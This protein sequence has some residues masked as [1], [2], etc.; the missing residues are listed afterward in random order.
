MPGTRLGWAC[1]PRELIAK[2]V[3]S[4]Q[5]TDQCAS[6][7]AQRLLEEYGRR[8]LLD[9]GIER[10]RAIYAARWERTRAALEREMPEGVEWWDTRGGFFTWLTLPRGDTTQLARAAVDAGVVFVPGAPFYADGR[11]Q[12]QLRLAFSLVPEDQ[13]DDGIARLGT[14]FASA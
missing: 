2:M 10:S 7:L 12:R 8:G 5:T 13:I 4:K 6:G 1:G 9:A 3:W 14:L 11:G